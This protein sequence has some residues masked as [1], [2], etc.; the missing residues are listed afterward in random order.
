MTPLMAQRNKSGSVT[1][2]R[3]RCNKHHAVPA[4][5]ASSTNSTNSVI[6]FCITSQSTQF[7]HQL[8]CPLISHASPMLS[9]SSTLE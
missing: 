2:S 4:N 7:A 9:N 3:K 5:S 8:L 6:Y 1:N